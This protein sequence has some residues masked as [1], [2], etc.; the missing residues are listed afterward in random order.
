MDTDQENIACKSGVTWRT[1]FQNVER[2]PK[3][4]SKQ[5]AQR[6]TGKGRGALKW[7]RDWGSAQLT[8]EKDCARILAVQSFRRSGQPRASWRLCHVS[9]LATFAEPTGSKLHP[10][11]GQLRDEPVNQEFHAREKM[12]VFLLWLLRSQWGAR[13]TPQQLR[14]HVMVSSVPVILS[15]LGLNMLMAGL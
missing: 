7:G 6:W 4:N 2:L 14:Y 1:C 10:G 9:Q 12:A 8:L 15:P 11:K 13:H 3:V 5:T